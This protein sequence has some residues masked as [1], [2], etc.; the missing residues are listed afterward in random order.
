MLVMNAAS[1]IYTSPFDGLVR[2]SSFNSLI[3]FL[4]KDLN[5][6]F[7]FTLF[8]L[9]LY[10]ETLLLVRWYVQL[11]TQQAHQYHEMETSCLPPSPSAFPISS[12][13]EEEDAVKDEN[14][15]LP[16]RLHPQVADKI[17]ELVSQGIEQV[18]AVRKQLRYSIIYSANY[19]AFFP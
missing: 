1:C 7:C 13:E 3:P 8:A 19:T 14:C 10:L 18:Y 16:S 5:K 9:E 2:G 15:T 6:W 12:P 4:G 17:R 11:P